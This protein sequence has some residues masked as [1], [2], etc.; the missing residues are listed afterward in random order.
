[1]D[2]HKEQIRELLKD[3]EKLLRKKPFYRGSEQEGTYYEN[4]ATTAR[5]GENVKQSLP[6]LEKVVIPQ[7]Q[8]MMELDPNSHK[9]LFDENIPCITQKIKGKYYEVEYKKMAIPYQQIIKNKH[10]LHLCGNDM[11][12]TQLDKN[13][14]ETQKANFITFKQYWDKRNQNGMRTKL[15]DTQLSYGD[16]ALLYYF[17]YKGR[18]KSRLLS[19]ADGYVL[20]TH[21]DDNGDRLL[22]CIYYANDGVEYLDCYDDTYMYRFTKDDESV[23]KSMMISALEGSEAESG[24]VMKG[25]PKKHGFSESPVVTKRGDVAWN[26]VQNIIEVYEVIYNIFLVI[27][28]RHGWGILYVKGKFKDVGHKIAGAVVLNDTT[29]SEQGGSAEFKT[30]P[31]PQ[32][33]IETLELMEEAIQKGSGTTFILPKDVKMSGDISGIALQIAQ[34]FDNETALT[35][36]IEY[37]NVADKMTRLFKEGLAKELVNDGINPKAVTEFEDLNIGSKFKVWRPLNETEYNNMLVT[38][39]G[40]GIISAQT[41]IEKNTLSTPDEVSR[42]ERENERMLEEQRNNLI[43]KEDT[44]TEI[45]ENNETITE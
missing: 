33:M 29:P 45:V 9:V 7:E 37:Q 42:I 32:G 15:V 16:G 27:Q 1:M 14:N 41:G 10:L 24:W 28:K 25:E 20:Y 17:D 26:N 6:D 36:A 23:K 35:N 21:D 13:P 11:V 38:L 5:I 34:S 22:D 40:A 8:F 4:M 43:P 31:S 19:F 30:P 2:N 18:I 44:K 12:F 39:K 3:P